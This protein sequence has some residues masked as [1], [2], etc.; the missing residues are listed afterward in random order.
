MNETLN[1]LTQKSV[2]KK[3][4]IFDTNNQVHN[5]LHPE[6]VTKISLAEA[7]IISDWIIEENKIKKHMIEKTPL[8]IM[9]EIN[10]WLWVV[11]KINSEIVWSMSMIKITLPNKKVMYE[12]GSLIT[13]PEKRGHWIAKILS[14]EIFL[15][16]MD[17]AVY[18][19]TEVKW[20]MHIYNDILKLNNFS[21]FDLDTEILAEIESVWA[22]LETDIIYWN[23]NFLELN[24]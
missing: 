21:K 6:I 3:P 22:L 24:K 5:I 2:E 20:V 7:K 12:A 10:S 13:S 17:K 19:I 8:Q 23:K 11:A 16:N 15:Q 4:L 14:K 9:Q 1:H 18:S